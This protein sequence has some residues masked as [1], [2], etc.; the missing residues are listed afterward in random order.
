MNMVISW[1]SNVIKVNTKTKGGEFVKKDIYIIRNDINDMVY[2]GQAKDSKQRFQSHCKPSAAIKN[3]EYIA[4]AI[5]A[6]GKEHFWYEI[7]ESQIEDYNEREKYWIKRLNSIVPNGY[8]ILAGGEAPPA[9]RG[10]EHPESKLSTSQVEEL[11][12]DLKNTSL[13][14]V[15]LAKKYGFKSNTSISEFNRG[16]T[17]VR[18]IKYPIRQECVNGKLTN[19]DVKDIIKLLKFT[20]RT[21]EDIGVQYGVEARTI[22]RINKGLF[23]KDEHQEYPIRIWKA[24]SSPL[25]LTYEEVSEIIF[26]LVST[27]LSLR[28]IAKRFGVEYKD[29][30]NIKNG[31]TKAYRRKDLT[32]PLRSNN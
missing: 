16:L 7:L 20:Y 25:K 12:S 23:H 5:Q 2:V 30:L 11:T 17:Y 10:V 8:N 21:F 3:N 31:T 15:E 19:Q 32:Y 4:K 6:N 27:R 9:L 18:K 28:E 13:T 29:I 26:L 24:T 1:E 14:F 22:S